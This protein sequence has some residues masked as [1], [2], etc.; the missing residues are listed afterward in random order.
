M[1]LGNMRAESCV[2]AKILT[3]G[4]SRRKRRATS[5]R[6]DARH[7]DIEDNQVG[8]EFPCFLKRFRSILCFSADGPVRLGRPEPDD[9]PL[10][11]VI[12]VCNQKAHFGGG[13]SPAAFYPT[14]SDDCSIASDPEAGTTGKG[15]LTEIVAPVPFD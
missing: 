15:S 7:T 6:V 8:Q 11:H 5:S 4:R 12:I 1:M 2:I 14:A 3:L 9:S 10:N 13:R